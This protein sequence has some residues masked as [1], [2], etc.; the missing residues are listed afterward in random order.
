MYRLLL[1][2]VAIAGIAAATQAAERVEN[3]L[4]AR[5]M[6]DSIPAMTRLHSWEALDERTLIV[7]T[8]PFQPYLVELKWPSQDLRSARAIGLTSYASRISARS[9]SVTVDGL[10]YPISRIYRLTREEVR[11][12][13]F[14]W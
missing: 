13:Q 7:W 12:D 2:I 5:T 11:D 10:H 4:E 1:G 9:D 6:V 3:G 14:T 8:T